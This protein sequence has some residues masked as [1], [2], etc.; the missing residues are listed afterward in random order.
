M[1]FGWRLSMLVVVAACFW[2]CCGPTLVS[3][4][5]IGG[6]EIRP[7]V[8]LLQNYS[9]MDISIPSQDSDATLILPARGTMEYTAWKPN[10]TLIGFVDG[11][12]VFCQH[13]RVQPQ[14]YTFFC[15]NYDFLAEIM[16]EAPLPGGRPAPT[17]SSPSRTYRLSEQGG[18]SLAGKSHGSDLN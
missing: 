6:Q 1:L 9:T 17:R 16:A 10:F 15:K 5:E 18:F 11:K 3:Q 14:R 8:G 4:D 12:E 13:V 2:G 7:Y